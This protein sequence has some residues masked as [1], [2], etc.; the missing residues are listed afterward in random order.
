[1]GNSENIPAIVGFG[2]H[3][4]KDWTSHTCSLQEECHAWIHS[5]YRLALPQSTISCPHNR[6]EFRRVWLKNTGIRKTNNWCKAHESP[7]VAAW[8]AK[9][10]VPANIVKLNQGMA[11]CLVMCPVIGQTV[12]W[13]TQTLPQ[14]IRLLLSNQPKDISTS[15]FPGKWHTKQIQFVQH[16][17][18]NTQICSH[19]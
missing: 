12:W 1:M 8:N 17:I 4:I 18:N 9:D 13:P 19:E 11:F 6:S 14:H 7:Q 16:C 2:V 5:C 15:F 10:L 3:N